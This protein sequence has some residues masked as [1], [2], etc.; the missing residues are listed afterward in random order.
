MTR[1]GMV[2]IG[3]L[4]ATVLVLSGC[5]NGDSG[6]GDAAEIEFFQ[7]KSES[8]EVVDTL[9]DEFESTH[10]G[11]TVTQTAVPDALTVLQ[12]R[13]A[14]GD[15]P[16]V[17]ALNVSNLNDISTSGLLKDLSGTAAA[18]AVDNTSAQDYVDA[19]GGTDGVVAVPWAVNAQVVLYDK[20]EFADLGLEVPT[21]WDEL[22]DVAQEIKDAGKEPFFFTWKDSWTAKLVFNSIAGS[23]Q[24][25]DFWSQLQA[26]DA[27][28]AGSPAYAETA[29]K[30]LELKDLAQPDPFGKGYDDGNTAFANGDSVMYIQGTWA[31]PE[32]RK[33]NPE[34]NI[35]TF[36]LPVGDTPE[37]SVLLSGPDSVIAVSEETQNA[38]A[39]QQFVDFLME[40]EAQTTFTEDQYLF[41]VRDDVPASDE[42]LTELKSDWLDQ[43]R[44]AMYPDSMFRGSS[45]L[46]ALVQQFLID[47]D[48]GV[49][50]DAMDADF[51]AHGVK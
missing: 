47:E 34:K 41:S 40:K 3:V 24:G 30:L 10:E 2:T 17:I 28:F 21:T 45:D 48:A 4:S 12:S 27:T 1:A 23:L 7:S 16:D 22:I 33:T 49:F 31:L 37:E 39:A 13:L 14:K 35:G 9:I 5:A 43:G 32:I 29:E 19:L 18:E 38:D 42:A 11:I 46:A 20:D 26:G 44:T 51:A 36:V 25:P 50:L 6:G 8:I 15:V